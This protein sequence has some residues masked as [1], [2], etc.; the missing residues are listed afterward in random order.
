MV[1]KYEL[2]D[3]IITEVDELMEARGI[4]KAAMGVEIVQKLKALQDGLKA[5]E[6]SHKDELSALRAQCGAVEVPI[7]ALGGIIDGKN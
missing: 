5:E 7:D 6:Q 1:N 4:R 3:S 2:I